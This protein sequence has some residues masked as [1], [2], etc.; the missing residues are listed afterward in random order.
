MRASELWSK[1]PK[2]RARWP[3]ATDCGVLVYE[4][5]FIAKPFSVL[6]SRTLSSYLDSTIR[7]RFED[8]TAPPQ[9]P[10]PYG[11]IKRVSAGLGPLTGAA[12]V[13]CAIRHKPDNHYLLPFFSSDCLSFIYCHLFVLNSWSG[14]LYPTTRKTYISA[15]CAPRNI[16][17]LSFSLLLSSDN[18]SH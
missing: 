15:R 18:A 4:P 2:A 14:D 6:F 3:K 16:I 8:T 5:H 13:R 1:G 10:L 7:W 9:Y 11:Q 17:C 12:H